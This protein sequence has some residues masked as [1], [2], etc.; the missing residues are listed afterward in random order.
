[1]SV[2]WGRIGG[3]T[4][5][6]RRTLV[7]AAII[8]RAA[9]LLTKLWNNTNTNTTVYESIETVMQS[10]LANLAYEL[11]QLVAESNES[12]IGMHDTRDNCQQKNFLNYGNWACSGMGSLSRSICSSY[13]GS[14][15]K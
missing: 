9:V 6:R 4:D 11:Q 3:D 8:R 14:S 1:M 10:D 15:A 12:W 7:L 5:E 13:L 2:S